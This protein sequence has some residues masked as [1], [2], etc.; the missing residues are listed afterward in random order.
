MATLSDEEL[1]QARID[2]AAS[3]RWAVRHGFNEGICNHFSLAV[4]DDQFLINAHGYHWSE[5]T[6]SSI[7]LA[8]YDG[9]IIEGDRDV[10]LAGAHQLLQ[11]VQ[12]IVARLAPEASVGGLEQTFCH[13]PQNPGI[14]PLEKVDGA[15]IGKP[16]IAKRSVA[17][18]RNSISG[19]VVGEQVVK[20][21]AHLKR[22]FVSMGLHAM[23]PTRIQQAAAHHFVAA[24]SDV[25]H[26][27]VG[28]SVGGRGDRVRAGSE[29]PD[30]R[31][32]GAA[33]AAGRAAGVDIASGRAARA[34]AEAAATGDV[35]PRA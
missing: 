19:C 32:A 23:D 11:S 1:Q 35:R 25:E 9:T 20:T 6:A 31:A 18:V 24:A 3:F 33:R 26:A 8:N 5:I 10:G 17:P 12:L 34:A 7:M 13:V 14:A 22:P 29:G 28:S 4:G 16:F 2:L 27:R 30:G 21:G 15:L